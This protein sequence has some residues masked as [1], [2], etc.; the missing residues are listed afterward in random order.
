MSAALHIPGAKDDAG[1]QRWGLVLGDFAPALAEV[2]KVGT[3]GA[4]K[5]SAAGWLQVPNGIERYTDAGLRHIA[6]HTMGE[7]HDPETGMPHLSHA[8]WNMLA[9]LTLQLQEGYE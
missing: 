9:V 4:R 8:A 6:A 5:Y 2:V 1:K 7:T 3:F